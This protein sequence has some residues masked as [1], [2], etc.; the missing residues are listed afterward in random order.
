MV[1]FNISNERGNTNS[2]KPIGISPIV[3]T[4]KPINIEKY[5]TK[6]KA[7]NA[8]GTIFEILLGVKNIIERVIEA[9][10]TAS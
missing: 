3:F 4:L 6:T 5:V 9:I 1:N 2:G 10:I 8:D 7:I